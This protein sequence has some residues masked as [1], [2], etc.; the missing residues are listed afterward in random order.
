MV[1]LSKC[2][3]VPPD[4]AQAKAAALQKAARKKP[5]LL[6]GVSGMGVREALLKLAQVI[7]RADQAEKAEGGDEKPWLPELQS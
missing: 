5:L 7:G 1:A 6:S 2:D 4:V 3:A